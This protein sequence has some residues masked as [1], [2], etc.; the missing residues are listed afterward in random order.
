MVPKGVPCMPPLARFLGDLF[1][2]AVAFIIV[3]FAVKLFAFLRGLASL[4]V[5]LF[6]SLAASASLAV[7]L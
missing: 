5:R 3:P 4:A 1:V 7:R 6:P 2:F